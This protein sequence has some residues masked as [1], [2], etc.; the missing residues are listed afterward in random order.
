MTNT[1]PLEKDLI[2]QPELWKL[3]LFLDIGTLWVALV[4]PV[5]SEQLIVRNFT[6]DPAAPA[7]HKA[8]ENIIYSNPLLLSDFKE[9][10]CFV[11]SP[12]KMAVPPQ[13]P[14]SSFASLMQTAFPDNNSVIIETP[15][16]ENAPVLLTA[17][18]ADTKGFLSRTFY[19]ITFHS[20]FLPLLRFIPS[21]QTPL[22]AAISLP[23]VVNVIAKKGDKTLLLNS[24]DANH[25]ETAAY[26]LLA[27]RHIL[28]LDD[29]PV[30]LFTCGHEPFTSRL[31]AILTK[32][33][34]SPR[35]LSLPHLPFL[36]PQ[37]TVPLQLL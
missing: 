30:S 12:H 31:N 19:N 22:I 20:Q 5:D 1:F 17:I 21:L 29:K 9:V 26:Y 37:Q 8:L 7:P 32:A 4:P 34:V 33:N 23:G 24:F 14:S 28:S 36:I 11:N 13:V 35:E 15:L 25:P 2:P 27:V 18:D 6:I 3:R 16:G 10:T